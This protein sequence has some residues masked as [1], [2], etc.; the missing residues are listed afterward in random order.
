MQRKTNNLR[1]E[2]QNDSEVPPI[3]HEVLRSPGQPLDWETRVFMEPRFGHDFTNVPVHTGAS[4]S[5]S[6]LR[7]WRKQRTR[8]TS[9]ERSCGD[10]P[11]SDAAKGTR[12]G[13]GGDGLRKPRKG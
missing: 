12:W 13:N 11:L 9:T 3:V 4:T 7:P 10:L 5:V 8:V 1:A 6:P 2:E